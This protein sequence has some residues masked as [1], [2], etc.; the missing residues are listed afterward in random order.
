[1]ELY[2]L[3]VEIWSVEMRKVYGSV[4]CVIISRVENCV[5]MVELY[6]SMEC[7]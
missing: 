6:G 5:E 3:S 1:M 4:E 7:A 2:A